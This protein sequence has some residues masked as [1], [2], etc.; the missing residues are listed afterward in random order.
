MAI[1][2]HRE[3]EYTAVCERC[4]ETES[5][6]DSDGHYKMDDT[7]SKYFRR[8]GWRDKDGITLCPDCVEK[9]KKEEAERNANS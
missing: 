7:P 5:I 4:G 9:Q 3:S 1:N 2:W 6:Y 8:Q